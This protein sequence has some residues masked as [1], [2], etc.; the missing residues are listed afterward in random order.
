MFDM[1]TSAMAQ[2]EVQVAAR[3]GHELPTDIGLDAKGNPTTNP[4][5]VLKGMLLPCGGH[6][7]SAIALMV[8]LLAAGAV[9]ERFSF[10]AEAADNGDGGPPRGGEFML[11]ISPELLAGEGWAEHCEAFF[12]RFESIE[13]ARLPGVRRHINRMSDEPRRI[14]AELI[15]T[16]HGLC[17]RS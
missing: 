13:G 9:G 16:I 8:E 4:N 3:D 11:A 10:E 7:G 5:E 1:A 15:K 2:G 17:N 14:N 12:K 6:K